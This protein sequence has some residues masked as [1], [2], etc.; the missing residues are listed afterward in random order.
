MCCGT[1]CEL[2]KSASVKPTTK[3]WLGLGIKLPFASATV[4]LRL[5]FYY[6]RYVLLSFVL[7]FTASAA[8]EFR[9]RDLSL[10]HLYR[11]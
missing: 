11:G 10:G 2:P 7:A 3:N 4:A 6:L 1:D 5:T 8:S 9:L